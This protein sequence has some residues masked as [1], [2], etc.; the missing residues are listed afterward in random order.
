FNDSTHPDHLLLLNVLR[1]NLLRDVKTET[2]VKQAQDVYGSFKD[3]IAAAGFDPKRVMTTGYYLSEEKIIRAIRVL[4]KNKL[5]VNAKQMKTMKNDMANLLVSVAVG[6]QTTPANILASVMR[7][8]YFGGSWTEAIKAA[9]L[10]P[11]QIVGRQAIETRI[12]DLP[13]LAEWQ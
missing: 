8:T 5:P 4:Y 9:G 2:F 3:A 6:R 10:D 7:R 12:S 11:E 1:A 13:H